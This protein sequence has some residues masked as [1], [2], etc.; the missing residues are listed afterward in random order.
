M[1]TELIEEQIPKLEDGPLKE[2]FIKLRILGSGGL[3]PEETLMLMARDLLFWYKNENKEELEMASTMLNTALSFL[4]QFDPFPFEMCPMCSNFEECNSVMIK[5][6]IK[7]FDTDH[8]SIEK[9][10]KVLGN[11]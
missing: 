9:L 5:Y 1:T 7:D 11:A 3:I 4:S 8:I 2:D 6:E 10:S